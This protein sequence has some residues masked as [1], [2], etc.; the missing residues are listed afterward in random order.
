MSLFVRRHARLIAC[1]A[2]ICLVIGLILLG[3][4]TLLYASTVVVSAE[5][6][7]MFEFADMPLFGAP[8]VDDVWLM[9]QAELALSDLIVS[10]AVDQLNLARDPRYLAPGTTY[11]EYL[12]GKKADLSAGVSLSAAEIPSWFIVQSIQQ[13]TAVGVVQS[14]AILQITHYA[15]NPEL[16]ADI[17]NALA[18]AFASDGLSSKL[19]ATNLANQWIR[20]RV[21]ELQRS[22]RN[23]DEAVQRYRN[24]NN[25]EGSETTS[26]VRE[27]LAKITQA[28]AQATSSLVKAESRYDSVTLALVSGQ[29]QAIVTEALKDT[30]STELRRR[31]LEAQRMASELSISQGPDH[32]QTRR[33]QEE[34]LSLEELMAKELA[35]IRE[36]IKSRVA[37]ERDRVAALQAQFERA[38]KDAGQAGAAEAGLRDLER[39][40]AALERVYTQFLA[41][42]QQTLLTLP[43][44][45]NEAAIISPARVVSDP[46]F[47]NPVIF[48]MGSLLAGLFIGS[49]L[50]AFIQLRDK[51]VTD[52]EALLS[53]YGVDLAGALPRFGVR[54]RWLRR[55]PKMGLHVHNGKLSY[56]IDHPF[57]PYAETLRRTNLLIN[58]D[59]KSASARM[60]GISSVVPMEGKS[61][62]AVNLS[63]LLVKEGKRVL[64]VD[65]S[66]RRKSLTSIIAPGEILAT[67][68]A[69][70]TSVFHDTATGLDF[71]SI[72]QF[73][74]RPSSNLELML[75][76]CVEYVQAQ[77][78][79]YDLI[80]FDMPD[81]S[82]LRHHVSAYDF[83]ESLILILAPRK[84]AR[85]AVLRLLEESKFIRSRSVSAV[86]NF[87]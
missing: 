83:V 47:P 62:F 74:S 56:A 82:S 37:I 43:V 32:V 40:Y 28:L 49:G 6:G 52:S 26:L 3:R 21:E 48:L 34:M 57:S 20:S 81:L 19:D 35:R 24:L 67:G 65:S 23:A 1:S 10:S 42:Y 29:K 13:S 54:H 58:R 50:A 84:T 69:D 66:T 75:K 64:L 14:D 59:R 63:L 87:R 22:V 60:V 7:S 68:G 2:L 53:S 11:L 9:T 77:A 39:E 45:L 70:E 72:S 25:L 44:P 86:L 27:D 38:L 33:Y 8:D 73:H 16:A 36:G 55:R 12:Q 18:R 79:S 41:R 76:A 78:S 4:S 5:R 17:A 30:N 61:T 85:K 80:I 71:L 15:A 51:S 46:V 31:Y